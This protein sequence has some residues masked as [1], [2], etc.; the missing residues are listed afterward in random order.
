MSKMTFRVKIEIFR[1]KLTISGQN[2]IFWS[3]MTFQI[4]LKVKIDI[5]RLKMAFFAQNDIYRSL[6]TSQIKDVIWGQNWHF[7]D[8]N[9]ILDRFLKH[10]LNFENWPEPCYWWLVIGRLR[11]FWIFSKGGQSGWLRLKE[12]SAPRD[13][14]P[15]SPLRW[16]E[17]SFAHTAIK[18]YHYN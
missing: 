3:L 12:W 15:W 6:M 8:R 16:M 4:E 17:S 2:D 14:P 1:S 18:Y 5:L 9:D 7:P 11:H 13:P 10:F